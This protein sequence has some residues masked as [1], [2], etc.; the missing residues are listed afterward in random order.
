MKILL[1]GGLGFIGGRFI[2][3]FFNIHE[4][5]VFTKK[6]SVRTNKNN[7]L[8]ILI[9][10]CIIEDMQT[11]EIIKK[12]KPNVVIHLAALTGLMKCEKNYY[13]AFL[14]N[15]LGT[16]NVVKACL[17][18]GSKLIF[19]SSREVYGETLNNESK[20]DDPLKPKNIYGVTKMIGEYLVQHAGQNYNLDYTILRLTN[21]YGPEGNE[22][23]VNSIVK[24]ALKKKKIEIHGGNQLL[25]LVYVDDVVELINLVL[26]DKRSSKQIFNVGSEDN[27]TIKEFAEEV[28][29][30]V[31]GNITFEYVSLPGV[32]TTTFRPSLEKLKKVL[33]FSSK[34]KLKDGIK[35]MIE[36]YVKNT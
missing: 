23:G 27:I 3:K 17:K 33:G 26:D 31:N 34:T 24:N 1:V 25:N 21:V 15:I 14:V 4:L 13:D 11:I 2:K 20:E 19:I 36:W 35:K 30:S 10:K 32:V 6:E 29:K 28:S 9:E 8:R 22:R 12:H 7:K 18:S 16:F 5:I